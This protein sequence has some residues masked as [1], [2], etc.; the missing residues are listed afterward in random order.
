MLRRQEKALTTLSFEEAEF[1]PYA[2]RPFDNQYCY[3]TDV[4]PIW[5]R[6]R[7]AFAKQVR[8][9]QQF[10]VT[11]FNGNKRNEGPPLSFIT[12]FCDYHFL[13]PNASAFPIR[14]TNEKDGK[15]QKQKDWFSSEGANLSEGARKYL[16][17]IGVPD[18]DADAEKAEM[19]W[20]HA[21][22]I[23]YSRA[24][25]T[26]NADGIRADW[27]RIPLPATLESLRASAKLGRRV[28]A[29]LNTELN[30]LG[31]TSGT[32]R[33]ELRSIAVISRLGGGSLQKGN[34]R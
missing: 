17:G 10:V 19:I 13:P 5:R 1:F 2:V 20:M 4:R 14:I 6:S 11:R 27:P 32:I 22:A 7:P 16:T 8:A 23:A 18:P 34:F 12:G 30:V 29:L 24:Y 26:E 15:N 33:D 9:N 28:A 3:Y 31:V 21:L 25:T